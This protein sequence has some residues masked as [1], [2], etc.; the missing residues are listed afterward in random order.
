MAITETGEPERGRKSAGSG[1][2]CVQF[3]RILLSH[4]VLSPYVL[5]ILLFCAWHARPGPAQTTVCGRL[6][7]LIVHKCRVCADIH[8]N[9]SHLYA[10]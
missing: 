10:V 9:V 7:S 2:F 1:M 3:T 5:F 8:C 4:C 6:V